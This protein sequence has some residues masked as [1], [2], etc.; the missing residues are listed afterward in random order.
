MAIDRFDDGDAPRHA[1]DAAANPGRRS[2]VDPVALA[3]LTDP[4]RRAAASRAYRALVDGEPDGARTPQVPELAEVRARH[5]EVF[6]RIEATQGARS[7]R[8]V[9]P[10]S[11]SLSVPSGPSHRSESAEDSAQQA[12]GVRCGKWIGYLSANGQQ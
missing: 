7:V 6:D 11:F 2:H 9:L 8:S 1:R 10:K 3:M 12:V 4:E 5:A